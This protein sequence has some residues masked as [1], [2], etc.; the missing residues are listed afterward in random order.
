MITPENPTGEPGGGCHADPAT[1]P[2]GKS[3]RNLGKGWKVN[4]FIPLKAGENATLMDVDG[5][6]VITYFWIAT[7]HNYMSELAAV[8]SI[9]FV[10]ARRCNSAASSS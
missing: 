2:F 1:A 3:A 7:D 10:S 9:S 4:P 5:P 6:G 8:V